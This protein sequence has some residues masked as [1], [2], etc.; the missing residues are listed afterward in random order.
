ME[1]EAQSER[2]FDRQVRELGLSTAPPRGLGTPFLDDRGANPKRDAATFD[3][4]LVVFS[5]VGQ[6][7]FGFVRWVDAGAFGLHRLFSW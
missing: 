6:A 1:D 4:R 5:G 3:E 7:I 2:S